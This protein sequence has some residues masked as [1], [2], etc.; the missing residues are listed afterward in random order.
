MR[1]LLL[2]FFFHQL[3]TELQE[4]LAGI[5]RPFGVQS[6]IATTTSRLYKGLGRLAIT[7][8]ILLNIRTYL[9]IIGLGEKSTVHIVNMFGNSLHAYTTLSRLGEYL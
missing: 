1:G 5:G 3:L 8:Q 4:Q 2:F 6:V 7:Q 9:L